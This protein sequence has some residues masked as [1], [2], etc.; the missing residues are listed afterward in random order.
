MTHQT[1]VF[2][3]IIQVNLLDFVGAK[4]YCLDGN[5]H[6]RIMEKMPEFSAVL[7]A[8]SPYLLND[9]LY[10]LTLYEVFLFLVC[11]FLVVVMT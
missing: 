3:A 4:Y 8:L 6:I 2:T 9:T 5:Q 1:P 10:K 11:V 7:A